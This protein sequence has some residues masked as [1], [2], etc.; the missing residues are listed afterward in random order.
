MY[1]DSTGMDRGLKAL[2]KVC[3]LLPINIVFGAEDDYV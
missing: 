2:N 1:Q 3:R